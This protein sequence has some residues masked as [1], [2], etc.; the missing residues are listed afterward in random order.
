L[1]ERKPDIPLLV[2]HFLE[3]YAADA[4]ETPR[5]PGYILDV[6]IQYDWPGNVRELQNLLQQYLAGQ[7]L[8]IPALMEHENTRQLED[9]V[10]LQLAN[11]STG[12]RA[13][14]EQ[15]EHRYLLHMLEQHHWHK[16]NTAKA[17]GIPRRTLYRKLNKYEIS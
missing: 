13:A 8:E 3:H 10:L 15:F 5:L 16:A 11:A 12:L 17:L 6:F 7:S 14:L 1:R 2:D 9:N 4:D